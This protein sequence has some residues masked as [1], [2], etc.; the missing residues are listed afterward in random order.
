[1]KKREKGF[2]IEK[3]RK[4]KKEYKIYL[5]K[6]NMKIILGNQPFSKLLQ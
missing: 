3:T 6:K 1:M 2:N 4:E 5:K